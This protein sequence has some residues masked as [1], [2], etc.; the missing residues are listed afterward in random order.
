MDELRQHFCL[1][2]KDAAAKLGV[3]LTTLKRICRRHGIERWPYRKIGKVKRLMHESKCAAAR[4]PFDYF[5][6]A[7]QSEGTD[8]AV[9]A[10]IAGAGAD[11]A[12]NIPART[13]DKT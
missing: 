7:M 6:L 3:A 8:A 2:L 4:Q 13:R 9:A 1:S 12:M 5:E 11:A 10:A